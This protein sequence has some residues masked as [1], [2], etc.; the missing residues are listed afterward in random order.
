MPI[1]HPRGD[2]RIRFT[3]Q[4][5]AQKFRSLAE[6]VLEK[7]LRNRAIELALKFRKDT[8]KEFMAA[9]L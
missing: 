6:P 5:L 1:S 2:Y 4:E 3:D 8:V 7:S 9:W